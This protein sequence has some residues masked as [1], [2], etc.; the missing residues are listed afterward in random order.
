MA[1]SVNSC[2]REGVITNIQYYSLHDGPGIRTL[3]FFKGCPLRCKWCC[4]PETQNLNYNSRCIR[5]GACLRVCKRKAINPDL[6]LKSGRKINKKICN[7]CGDCV[8]ACP[9][10]ALKFI[11]KVISVDELLEE[12]KKDR[13]FYFTSKGGLTI[14]GGEALFQIEFARELLKRSYLILL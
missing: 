11:G 9:T 3:V 4:N 1:I 6:E 2:S 8:K 5:C 14:S 10:G 13:Y 12:I 7:Y